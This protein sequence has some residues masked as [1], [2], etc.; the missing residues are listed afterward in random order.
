MNPFAQRGDIHSR[1]SYLRR[2]KTVLV[3]EDEVLVRMS[4]CEILES[5]GYR[6]LQAGNAAEA[7]Q[8]FISERTPVDLLLCDAVLPDESGMSLA[9][10]LR[11]RS[12]GL[13]TIVAS[14]YP[15]S[16]LRDQF[17]LSEKRQ[18]LP[19]PYSAP[20]LLAKVAAL[21]QTA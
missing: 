4:T 1:Q 12:P 17:E 7:R 21:L 5:A 14:G 18:I 6:V 10:V 11:W 19:K 2:Q 3:V 13:R 15:R 9:C 8:I 16:F 20:L